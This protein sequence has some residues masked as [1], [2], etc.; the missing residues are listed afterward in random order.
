MP[1]RF[2]RSS[3]ERPCGANWMF[4]VPPSGG[5]FRRIRSFQED[6]LKAE[7][8][9]EHFTIG[10]PMTQIRTFTQP[11]SRRPGELGVH[12]LDHFNFSVPDVEQARTFYATFGLDLRTEA[13]GLSLHTYGHAH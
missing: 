3:L 12:S 9:L 2:S 8:R 5:S 6:L 13:G 4:G 7:P 10:V 11:I 1:W